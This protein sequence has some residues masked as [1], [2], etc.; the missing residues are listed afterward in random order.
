MLADTKA[1][2]TD[3]LGVTA[4]AT[5]F[6]GSAPATVAAVAARRHIAKRVQTQLDR[7]HDLRQY[8]P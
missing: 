3:G 1:I 6:R 5:T 7:T 4:S 2:N 8:H